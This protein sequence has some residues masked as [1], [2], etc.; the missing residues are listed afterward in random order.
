MLRFSEHGREHGPE[1]GRQLSRW[2]LFVYE[3]QRLYEGNCVH[4]VAQQG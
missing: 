3:A 4:D 2:K 1:D